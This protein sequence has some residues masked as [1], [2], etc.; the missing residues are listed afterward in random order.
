MVEP[1]IPGQRP[2][3]ERRLL[4]KSRARAPDGQVAE[5]DRMGRGPMRTTIDL[6]EDVLL[7]VRERARREGRTAGAVLSE[8]ARQV[9]TWGSCRVMSTQRRAS[10][11]SSLFRIEGAWCRTSWSTACVKA[12]PQSD[13][14]ARRER[15]KRSARGSARAAR[16]RAKRRLASPSESSERVKGRHSPSS[17]SISSA[18]ARGARSRGSG[19]RTRWAASAG[20]WRSLSS[21]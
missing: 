9:L 7:A 18:L 12:S 2:R 14:A 13:R 6:D 20:S 15:P 4:W 3:R 17:T 16:K 1:T 11:G 19:R 10:A 8:L 21:G 5:N